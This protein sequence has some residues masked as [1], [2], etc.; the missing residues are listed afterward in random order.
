MRDITLEYLKARERPL[1]SVF[2]ILALEGFTDERHVAE[3][4]RSGHWHVFEYLVLHSEPF[5]DL[6]MNGKLI[7]RAAQECLTEDKKVAWDAFKEAYE[8]LNKQFIN[9]S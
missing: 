9:L 4:I 2:T 6:K 5:G 8:N 1:P 3:A 7:S